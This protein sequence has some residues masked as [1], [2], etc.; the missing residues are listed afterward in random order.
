MIFLSYTCL[1]QILSRSPSTEVDQESCLSLPL[2]YGDVE[3][4]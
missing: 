4:R 1:D 3:R 2:I